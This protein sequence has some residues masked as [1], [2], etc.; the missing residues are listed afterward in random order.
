MLK[1]STVFVKT[2]RVKSD[3]YKLYHVYS[4]CVIDINNEQLKRSKVHT[5]AY[6][7]IKSAH[8]RIHSKHSLIDT[9]SLQSQVCF[10]TG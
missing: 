1:F 8:N 4:K 10:K 5:T 6:N 3:G 2:F 9:I 7:S